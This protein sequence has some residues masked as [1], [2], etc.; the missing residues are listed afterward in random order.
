MGNRFMANLVHAKVEF[1]ILSPDV[2][3][4]GEGVNHPSPCA[5]I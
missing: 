4:G 3:I 5:E 1:P 2:R